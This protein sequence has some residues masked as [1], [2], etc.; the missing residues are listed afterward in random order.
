MG[1]ICFDL[2]VN[3]GLHRLQK[4]NGIVR[5]CRKHAGLELLLG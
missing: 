5:S 3:D 1:Y 4:P 2:P